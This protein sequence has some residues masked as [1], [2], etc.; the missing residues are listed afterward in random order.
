MRDFYDRIARLLGE[1]ASFVI[2]TIVKVGGSSPRDAGAKMV[3]FE[4]G[5]AEGTLGGGKLE[6][7]VIQDA[8]ECLKGHAT[9]VKS[10]WLSEDGLGMKCGGTVEVYYEPVM[11]TA[12]LVVFGGGHVGRAVARLAPSAGFAVEVVDDRPEHL[13]PSAFPPEVRLLSTDSTFR[14]G[15]A[16][17]SSGDFAVVVTRDA[18]VDAALAGR[19]AG[20]CTY[21]G[22]MGSQAKRA[23]MKREVEAQGVPGEVFETVRCPMGVDIGADTPEEIA[24]SVVA[25]MIATRSARRAPAGPKPARAR[26]RTGRRVASG[27]RSRK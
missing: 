14:D 6:A 12:R 4:D 27:R 2:A 10:Y 9:A 7:Q 8:L 24:V 22:V 16:P 5:S 21:V 15:Y 20:V 25:E 23:F 18:S 19:W 3:V 26:P 11:P 1:H 13:D 17:L